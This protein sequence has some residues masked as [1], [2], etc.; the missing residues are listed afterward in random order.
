MASAGPPLLLHGKAILIDL[1]PSIRNARIV[2]ASIH[3]LVG[4][5]ED[6][7]A[8]E[9]ELQLRVHELLAEYDGLTARLIARAPGRS[10]SA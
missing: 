3:A 5:L 9:D 6:A 1:S 7:H 8:K 10:S 2:P 4:R